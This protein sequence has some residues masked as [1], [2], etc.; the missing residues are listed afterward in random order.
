MMQGY[1]E[2]AVFTRDEVRLYSR[3]RRA[4]GAL[5]GADFDAVR[6]HE[7]A[8]AFGEVLGLPHQDGR[9]QGVEHTWLWTRPISPEELRA[10]EWEVSNPP[11]VLDVYVPGMVPIV[12]LLDYSSWTLPWRHLYVPGPERTDVL[13]DEV[14]T[15]VAVIR[16]VEREIDATASE[17]TERV[18]ARRKPR[19]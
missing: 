4:S 14:A 7:L 15:L 18:R 5:F 6:C 16:M 9:F 17:I 10:N 19:G 1:A 2:R 12:A 3:A 13:V 11:N 8:R